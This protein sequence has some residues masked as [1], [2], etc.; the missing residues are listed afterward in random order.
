[1]AI[2][3]PQTLTIPAGASSA[4]FSVLVIGDTVV[5]SVESVIVALSNPT[6]GAVLVGTTAVGTIQDDDGP[7]TLAIFGDSTHE[8]CE[9]TT[10]LAFDVQLSRPV[11]STVTV[12]Y[13]TAD[14]TATAGSD[15]QFASG[16]VT[17]APG[18][19]EQT[20]RV[21]VIGDANVETDETFTVNLTGA[22]GAGVS[23]ASATGT[24]INDD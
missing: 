17:F 8:G 5:E 18:Q 21:T 12:N 4:T 10:T 3:S 20:I 19:T 2:A 16:T 22:S 6:G 24:I 9:G 23:V 1:V 15:Y 11:T 7:P 14:G 13:A